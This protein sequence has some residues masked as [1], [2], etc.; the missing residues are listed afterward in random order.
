MVNYSIFDFCHRS[1]GNKL[2]FWKFLILTGYRTRDVN[3]NAYYLAPG[4]IV[5]PAGALGVVM[6]LESKTQRF[7]QGRH[8]EDVTAITVHPSKRL[9]ATG[10]IV[11]TN[12]GTYIYIWDPKT[13]EDAH[14][15]VQIRVG[16]KKL[17]KGV[18]DLQFSP[19]GKYL[20]AAT[21]D[22][23]H[24]VYVYDWQKA[25]KLIAKEKGHTDAVRT[26]QFCPTN[27]GGVVLKRYAF[28]MVDIWYHI[29]SQIK[30]R[31]C[32]L[33]CETLEILEIR[34][35]GWEVKGRPWSI[36]IQKGSIHYLLYLLAQWYICYWYT[37]W[38]V[39]ILEW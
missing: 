6:D 4:L 18:A 16:E 11:S 15:Q 19:C 20:V 33:R 13:P 23:D 8:K 3:N 38:R 9:V 31:I 5:F 1:L 34:H 26:R 28:F 35:P 24:H 17:A 37:W 36:W 10:D 30:L 22:D 14:R 29:Q 21:M 39:A 25:G 32:H 7:F 12:D 2:L 27:L